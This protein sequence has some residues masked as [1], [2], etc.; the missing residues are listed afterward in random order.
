MVAKGEFVVAG[1][2]GPELLEAVEEPLDQVALAVG[3]AVEPRV[4][5]FRGA[6]GNDGRDATP[7]QRA[8]HGAAAVALVTGHARRPQ[9]WP[10]T[11][12]TRNRRLLHEGGQ[13]QVLMPLARRQHDRQRFATALGTGVEF[14][15]EA[16]A[17]PA[18]RLV[19]RRLRGAAPPFLAPAACWW[20]RTTE[21]S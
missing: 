3:G 5:A 21:P 19:G 8:P 13:R 15:A 11:T 9:P 6:G 1:G 14:G 12:R 2:E 16:A 17:T 18:K 10:P 20:A 7:P 4:R